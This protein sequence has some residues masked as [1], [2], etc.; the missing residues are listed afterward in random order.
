MTINFG[1]SV[2]DY[3]CFKSR[4]ASF[5]II[6]NINLL[7]G[8][9]N[10]GKSTFLEILDGLCMPKDWEG[11]PFSEIE[12]FETLTEDVF[13]MV[14]FDEPWYVDEP[15]PGKI[16]H[17]HLKGAVVSYL[18]RPDAIRYIGVDREVVG[19][20]EPGL[21]ERYSIFR[22]RDEND[23]A[24]FFSDKLL[25]KKHV[26][27]RADRDIV[28]EYDDND[29]VFTGNGVGATQI[30]H[31]LSHHSGHDRELITKVL[32]DALNEIFTPDTR[33]VEITT[34]YHKAGGVWEIYLSE[35]NSKLYPLSQSGSGLKTIILV[36]LNLLIR[37]DIESTSVSDY[38][39][40]FEEL[41]NNLHPS[42][43]RNLFRYLEVFAVK[44]DCHMFITTHSNIAIDAYSFSENA[45]INHIQKEG[46]EVVGSVVSNYLHKYGV[47]TDLGNKA[48]DL[49]QANG[50]I[51]IEG[52]SDRIYLNKFLEI[53]SDGEL[54]EGVH[55]Q[56]AF[57]GGSL[58]SHLEMSA[59]QQEVSEA[60]SVLRVNRN[61]VLV[62][63]G[64]QRY[65][66]DSL[67][68]RVIKATNALEA[69]GGYSWVT[70]CKEIE[71]LIPKAA[72]QSVNKLADID[73]IDAYEPIQE[74]LRKYGA[75]QSVEFTNKVEKAK[76]Y[77]EFFTRDNLRFRPEVD[78][79]MTEICARIRRWNFMS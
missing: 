10:I 60:L 11:M 74:F 17:T 20:E 72:F 8:R 33:F 62:C 2:K 38:I 67:K 68:E 75:T 61:A 1:F 47:L 48:S 35:H 54:R 63:D 43:Q 37:P 32:L 78:R 39:F 36:L 13:R 31:A 4:G 57:F 40:S 76:L 23:G 21:R 71:N 29:T 22:P 52:P 28:P 42:L 34:K 7:V 5:H 44:N 69:A 73:D 6:K 18:Q 51:W 49:L 30:V 14:D 79:H 58:L 59:P 3:K 50:L 27:L 25:R 70:E 19:F 24:Y 15:E 26:R 12:L 45:Q 64:D 56:F 55:F 77:A 65:E 66:T 41:E 53:W 16:D 9:N 46:D